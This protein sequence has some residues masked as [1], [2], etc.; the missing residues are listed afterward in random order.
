MK[1]LL[2][3]CALALL[4]GTAAPL[5]TADTTE[6]VVCDVTPD[7]DGFWLACDPGPD[8]YVCVPPELPGCRP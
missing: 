8:M 7:G 1:A 4:L 5:A 3:L 2:T 6:R